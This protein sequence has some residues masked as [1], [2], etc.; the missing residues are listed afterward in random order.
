[1]Q[2]TNRVKL[3]KI[4]LKLAGDSGSKYLVGIGFHFTDGS[5]TGFFEKN[6]Q[7]SAPISTNGESQNQST[8]VETI[9]VEVNVNKTIR[10]I[11]M[12]EGD[13]KFYGMRFGDRNGTCFFNQEWS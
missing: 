8:G 4:S 3:N 13:D 5:G 12:K 1:M 2:V 10:Y 6:Q 9:Q 7:Y 11:L